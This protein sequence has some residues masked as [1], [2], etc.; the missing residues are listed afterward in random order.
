MKCVVQ[1]V[2]HC[3]VSVKGSLI[4]RIGRGLLVYLGVGETDEIGD[5]HYLVKKVC[6]LRIFED[7][8]GKMNLS[9]FDTESREIMVISQFTLYGDVRKGRRPSFA[10]AAPP[11]KGKELYEKFIDECRNIGLNPESGSFGSSMDIAYTNNGPVTIIIDSS[12]K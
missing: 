6:N 5:V 8:E 1:R 12:K 9:L 7:Q 11:E 2:S 10:K 4:S 3:S